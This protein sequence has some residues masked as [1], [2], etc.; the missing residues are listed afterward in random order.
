MARSG[1]A[2][3]GDRWPSDRGRQRRPRN[4]PWDDET[5]WL[6]EHDAEFKFDA[7][8]IRHFRTPQDS[9]RWFRA[10]HGDCQQCD[11]TGFELYERGG[12]RFARRCC[13]LPALKNRA[14]SERRPGG[15]SKAGPQEA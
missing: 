15:W 10:E 6:V 11:G 12:A 9:E 8:G 3:G 1:D 13:Y 7:I 14:P 5:P 2:A 4:W